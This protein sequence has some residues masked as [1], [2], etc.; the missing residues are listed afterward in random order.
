M[1]GA[2]D[3]AADR[4]LEELMAEVS[5]DEKIIGAILGLTILVVG[6]VA[7]LKML[8]DYWN[9][10]AANDVAPPPAAAAAHG[11]DGHG[12]DGHGDDGHGDDGHGDQ[13]VTEEGH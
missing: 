9:A 4:R 7:G 8:T 12:D 3:D 1:F 13:A 10:Q 6:L 11:G 2:S 5:K